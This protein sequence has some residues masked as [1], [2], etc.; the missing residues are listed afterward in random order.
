MLYRI[1]LVILFSFGLHLA[2]SIST[3]C[4]EHQGDGE[5]T[6]LGREGERDREREKDFCLDI[7]WKSIF[8][9]KKKQNTLSLFPIDLP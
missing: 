1:G 8:W 5:K 2:V 9:K 3:A 6:L 7:T 4:N